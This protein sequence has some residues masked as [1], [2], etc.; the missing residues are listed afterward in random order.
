M[1]TAKVLSIAI[2]VISLIAGLIS[3][4]IIS[5]LSKAQK[6]KQME[7]IASQLINFFI[8]IWLGKII[9]NFFI[10]IKDPLAILAYPSSSHA[11]YLAILFSALI[12]TYK[13]KRRQIDV[14]QLIKSFIPVFLVASFVYE[15]IQIVW[16]NNT[17]SIGYTV[18]LTILLIVYLLVSDRMAGPTVTLMM[19]IGWSAGVFVLEYILSFTTVFGYIMDSWFIGLF[20]ITSFILIIYKQ[21]KLVS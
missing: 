3:F 9:M 8:F 16:N 7:E 18:L 2:I 12:L 5:G 17:Y 1:I 21:R 4:Y 13:S 11:F 20:F 15:F 14:F 6:K 19:L 10:F